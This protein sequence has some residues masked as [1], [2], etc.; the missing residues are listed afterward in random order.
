MYTELCS[1]KWH[2]LS[3]VEVGPWPPAPCS[4][5]TDTSTQWRTEGG[6][7]GPWPPGAILVGGA[8]PAC[9]G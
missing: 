2:P 8:R 6:Q 9:R 4:E 7:G 5:M 3:K 1:E